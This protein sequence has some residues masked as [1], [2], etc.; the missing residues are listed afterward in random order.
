MLKLTGS[1]EP[2]V[3]LTEKAGSLAPL[4]ASAPKLMV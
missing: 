1:A 2:A 4:F 3:A